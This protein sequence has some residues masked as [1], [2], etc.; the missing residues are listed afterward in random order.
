MNKFIKVSLVI[1]FFIYYGSLHAVGL[2]STEEGHA[3]ETGNLKRVKEILEKD[4]IFTHPRETLLL[5]Q[6]LELGVRSG[7]LE[8]VK[9]L[10]SKGWLTTCKNNQTNCFPIHYVSSQKS[11]ESMPLVKFFIDKGFSPNIVD[12]YSMTTLHLAAKT[13]KFELVRYLCNIGVDEKIKNS[14][15]ETALEI[16]KR[17]FS[18]GKL[19]SNSKEKQ[20]IYLGL[21]NII[22][23]LE[24]E[25][26][27]WINNKMDTHHKAKDVFSF[28]INQ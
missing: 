25:T 8:L 11:I 9:Y 20:R 14:T 7:N 18:R 13:G 10:D 1:G 2:D 24:L 22:E 19:S 23:F 3:F 28:L 21:K 16:A 12:K 26:I 5:I 6:A 15:N 17:Y 27:K 4:N